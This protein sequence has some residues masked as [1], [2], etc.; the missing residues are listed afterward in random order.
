ML[1]TEDTVTIIAFSFQSMVSK[2]RNKAYPAAVR[3]RRGRSSLRA[4]S[5]TDADCAP[6]EV[7][8]LRSRRV[9][10]EAHGCGYYTLPSAYV[11]L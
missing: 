5:C 9:L 2:F 7:C 1:G 4:H 10:H 8:T 6:T 11:Q 3:V